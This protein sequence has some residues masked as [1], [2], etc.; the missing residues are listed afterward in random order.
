MEEQFLDFQEALLI[1]AP[2]ENNASN[3]QKPTNPI[4]TSDDEDE[5]TRPFEEGEKKPI[6][7][8]TTADDEDGDSKPFKQ[9]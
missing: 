4:E 3:V 7:P 5:D 9:A 8:I 2:N 1:S 6:E